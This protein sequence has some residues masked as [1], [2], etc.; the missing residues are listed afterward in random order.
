MADVNANIGVNID[1]SAALAQL[2]SLQRQ[3]SQF[4]TSIS[5][6]SESAAIAQK[7]LQKN[8]LNSVNS[9]GAF[10]AELRTVKT[11]A[12]SFTASLEGNKFSMREYFRYAGASTKTFGR[13]FKSEFDTI[14][15]V[16]E[17]RVKRLQTQYI[18]LGRDTN[19]AMQALA[20]TPTSLNMNDYGTR[21]A[22]AAQKQALFN[23][24][25]KQG[26]TNLLNFGKNTQWAGRQ[27]MVG[28]TIP[29]SIV[30]SAA[31]KTFMD[32][33]AQALKFKKVYGDLFTPQEETQ[34][35]LDNIT[36]LGRGFTKYGIAVSQT[37]GLAS[38]AAAA[39]FQGL[40]L[41]RQTT[42]ATRLSVLG[43]I[44]SQKALETT[45]ALQNAFGMSS[46]KLAGSID[47][48]NAV[49][50][51]TVVSLDDITTA[52]PKVAPVIQQLGGDVKDLTFFISAM[53]E[54][55]INASEGANALKSGL[56]A[57]I[58]P[59][60]RASEMLAQ[61]G[62]NAREIVTSNKGDLKATVIE[63]ATALNQLD[64]LNRAQAI[65][66]MFG[67]FQFARL[68]T[69]FANV[70]KEGNQASRV[71]ALANSSV[72]ELS[73]LSEKELGM[74]AESSM[75]K[76][77]KTVED[78]KVALIPVGKAFLE[79]VTPILEFVA[80]ALE[81]F[82]N[83]SDGTK[84]VV[85]LITLGIAGLGPIFLMTFGLLA[86]LLA[87]AVKGAMI[88]RN[89]YLRLTGQS[90]VLG[91][92]TQ[93]LTMEQIEAAA[94]AHSLDQSHARLTQQ[95]TAEASAVAKLIAVY[96]Q[97]TVAGQKFMLNNPG[98]MLP[99]ARKG[100]ANGVI[101]V[102]GSGKGDTVPAML[103]PGEAVIPAAMAKKYAP[104]IEGMIAGNIPG[105][106]IGKK[107]D[108]QSTRSQ[109]KTVKVPGA[110]NMAHFGEKSTMTGQELL[111]MSKTLDEIARKEIEKLVG[112]IKNGVTETFRVFDNRVVAQLELIN[113]DMDK[114]GKASLALT[115][116]NVIGDKY[117]PVRDPELQTQLESVGVPLERIKD[118]N[119]QLT[120]EM[121]KGFDKLGNVTEIT[122]DQLD[123]L[124]RE[125]YEAVA[126]T[127]EDVAKAYEEMKKVR[128]AYEPVTEKGKRTKRVTIVEGSYSQKNYKTKDDPNS[129]YSEAQARMVGGKDN[130]PYPQLSSFG[131]NDKMLQG[132]DLS[133][134][135]AQAKFR[136]LSDTAKLELEKVAGDAKE[137]SIAFKK[138]I[139]DAE[140]SGRTLGKTAV[141]SIGKGAK[142]ASPSKDTIK[143]GEDIGKGLEIGMQ[144]RKDEVAAVGTDLGVA[145]VK[146]TQNGRRVASRPEGA[147]ARTPGQRVRRSASRPEGAPGVTLSAVA[148]NMPVGP[149]TIAKTLQYARATEKATERL[150]GL[151]R[152]IMGASF[153]ISSLSGLASMS[154]GKLGAMSATISKVTG[155]MFALQAITGLL[156]QTKAL[157]LIQSRLST[158]SNAMRAVNIK[159]GGQVTGLLP[160]LA[161]FGFGLK[162][163]LGPIGIAATAATALYV[164]FRLIQKNQEEA[165]LKIEGL[166]NAALLT[167]EQLGKLGPLLGF[168]PSEDPFANIGQETK[169]VSDPQRQK[170]TDIKTT[171]KE[172]KTFQQNIKSLKDASDAQIKDV[173]SAQ[174]VSL[175]S[176]GA[177]KENVQAYINALLE[178]AGKSKI[179]FKVE[180]IDISSK[181]GQKEI[182]KN[183]KKQAEKFA[184]SYAHSLKE[185]DAKAERDLIGGR[186][187][188]DTPQKKAEY[189]RKNM[190]KSTQKQLNIFTKS[191]VA[192]FGSIKKSLE[193]GKI[194]VEAY[195][196]AMSGLTDNL[197]SG[198]SNLLVAKETIKAMALVGKD[199]NLANAAEG[200]TKNADAILVLEA[201]TAGIPDMVKLINALNIVSS[202]TGTQ[203]EIDE[204]LARIAKTRADIAKRT[205]EQAKA[206]K[207]NV[208]P[209]V[210]PEE[211]GTKE[212]TA[213]SN[214]QDKIKAIREQAKA[215]NTLRAAGVN[216]KTASDMAS[217]SLIA[218]DVA[219]GKIKAGTGQW[220]KLVKQLQAA[221]KQAN[222]VGTAL[223]AATALTDL[224]Q[225]TKDINAQ[226]DAYVRLIKSGYDAKEAEELVNDVNMANLINSP[227]LADLSYKKLR[228][229][230]DKNA[231]AL[232]SFDMVKD[233]FAN[234]KKSIEAFSQEFDKAMEHFRIQ[235][236]QISQRFNPLIEKYKK[237]VD[238]IQDKINEINKNAEV[239]LKPLNDESAILSN[240]LSI[241]D[242]QSKAINDKYDLQA[243]ALQKISDINSEI[244]SQ[245]K[246][247]LTLADALSQGD[248]SAAAAAA[249]DMRASA[250]QN[251]LGQQTGFLDAA[252][253]QELDALLVNG[254]T[255]A[256]IEERQ[257]Q[258]SQ[259]TYAI[260]Q[261][262][263]TELNAQ[264]IE[265]EAAQKIYDD[266]QKQFD[267][268]L[269][270]IT[271]Q[272]IEWEKQKLIVDA[273]PGTLENV[274]SMLET[275]EAAVLAI[276]AAWAAVAAAQASGGGGGGGGSGGGGNGTP[277]TTFSDPSE[278]ILQAIEEGKILMTEAE[279]IRA[280]NTGFLS[281]GGLVPKYFANGGLS[282]GTDTVPAMLTPGEFVMRKSAV[283]KFGPL[284]SAINDPSFK[285][286]KSSSYGGA[287]SGVNNIVDNSSAMYNYNIGITVP[288]SNANPN[289][290][291]NAVIGQIKY[292]D[293]QRIRG[294]R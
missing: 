138:A 169:V 291:A 218:A 17:E 14:G 61:F 122:S 174:A 53:K 255:R 100:Y 92:Q 189:D 156:T 10:S 84:K 124:I 106:E 70:T 104:L 284:L 31:T 178:E 205:A 39:G 206:S 6:S 86:N 43:Q 195:N 204:A 88:L 186:K 222:K 132:I 55:G 213:L 119:Q 183:A 181:Q 270:T 112:S 115:K 51:Q 207:A 257:Y 232:G 266:T 59:T 68:S 280:M 269:K 99:G 254:M 198:N 275:Q 276:A 5:K 81:K 109:F 139:D 130:L 3:I 226:K 90:Q 98:M 111:N 199:K 200:I 294:Q 54:G 38:E 63:F 47:F 4:H 77:K 140:A 192:S 246:Q 277:G 239:A 157:E 187:A 74:T 11:S 102:P 41:Q 202:G 67:K 265:L 219:A 236:A 141:D 268:A 52:I 110:M 135:E 9:I 261:K 272:K 259:L 252:R 34:A 211:T 120:D 107:G 173:V 37:V 264:N 29:L 193:T 21:T 96:Q 143:T 290:I 36:E 197:K 164:G 244:A 152:N 281:S 225:Q 137:F 16:A 45:I 201:A 177:P 185:T 85:T 48:L 150:K 25:M 136:N 155:A 282:R 154:G 228:V 93:Y 33:E 210:N 182:V 116:E 163:L 42:E 20:V 216:A 78:L 64:P 267:A 221:E 121:K 233:P 160:K 190:A 145:A 153:A 242:Y 165:R 56:A 114:K 289:D 247:Q 203:K 117:A 24:L 12:E 148:A 278:E 250:A 151:D 240:S 75:N 101:S 1:T 196:T 229:E 238:E 293:A 243:N 60:G 271:D 134:E 227:K 28:F 217:D 214:M 7:S 26:S 273:L 251:A 27:L 57:L 95:F 283:D 73:S 66:Q 184:K 194:G 215:Y 288:Q 103:T 263:N 125:A 172:D 32:M 87:N 161:K 224:Q 118:I 175:L 79:A 97:A 235:E 127:N 108:S 128:S 40:D 142:T 167:S 287:S 158:A 18:K 245:Q 179:D 223:G 191:Q 23:Q 147:P 50:N 72:E 180:S 22:M 253:K 76:F 249:Q 80:N 256:Q 8:L 209:F 105:Y 171:L 133:I 46:E 2:K 241:I 170:I 94:A 146:G 188:L 248:I 159:A 166:G 262:R 231:K 285:M 69:L 168:T 71:L 286:P 35:A 113:N 162:M 208:D 292:I 131:I 83:L 234:V 129:V 15:K 82:G 279:M 176:Q 144:N 126:A 149:D 89:G 258:I 260:E 44:D 30:G 49:E 65:E 13:L 274:N 19:G 230:I 237:A 58:N 91:E 212:A 123:K 62:I 220:A